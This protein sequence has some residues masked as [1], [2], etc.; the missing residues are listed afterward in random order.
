MLE[1]GKYNDLEVVKKVDFGLYLKSGELEILLPLKY[2]AEG[3]KIGDV[4]NVFI[5]KDSEDRVIATTLKPYAI[6]DEFAFLR[7]KE[8]NQTGAFLDWGIEK[9]LVVPFR[10]QGKKME[11]GKKY[12]V[13]IY[14]DHSSERLAASAL[15]EQVSVLVSLGENK[16]RQQNPAMASRFRNQRL[17][18]LFQVLNRWRIERRAKCALLRQGEHSKTC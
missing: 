11:E 17:K 2:I 7:V 18:L 10:E 9:D 3:T 6:V 4:L 16:V 8:V 13:R 15:T 5:Y 1:I 14:L 12:V